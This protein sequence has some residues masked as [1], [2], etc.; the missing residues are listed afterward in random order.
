MLKHLNYRNCIMKDGGTMNNFCL[1][2]ISNFEYKRLII[3]TTYLS[4][5][6]T[7]GVVEN[8][9]GQYTGKVLFDLT[10]INGLSSNRYLEAVIIDG[11]VDR[12]SFKVVKS[13]QNDIKLVSARF[14]RNN[15]NIVES[16]TIPLALKELIVSGAIV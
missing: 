1:K 16:G 14:F 7:L 3:A 12:R 6:Q 4:P 11:K 8:E 13:V 10:V 5:I 2:E 15:R 9:L